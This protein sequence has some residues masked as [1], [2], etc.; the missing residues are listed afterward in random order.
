M[1]LIYLFA[2][3]VAGLFVVSACSSLIQQEQDVFKDLKEVN[4][5]KKVV[6]EYS[7]PNIAKP[8]GLGHLMSTTIGHSLA[9]IYRQV[10][11]KVITI[12]HLGDWGTQFGFLILAY[13]KYGDRDSIEKD[14]INELNKL[15]IQINN[16]A[17]MDATIREAAKAEFVKLEQGDQENRKIWKLFQ[18]NTFRQR[19]GNDKA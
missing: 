12:N 8:F 5:G 13:K 4:K 10:G 9:R 7:S 6:V 2:V 3:L 14:P 17:E 15:Y 16:E 18:T 11:Y 19:R 1:K